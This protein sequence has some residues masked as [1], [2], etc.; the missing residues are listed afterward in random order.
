MIIKILGLAIVLFLFLL[1]MGAS[2]IGSIL[3]ALFGVKPTNGFNSNTQA[4]EQPRQRPDT[5]RTRQE[6]TSDK[7]K[8]FDDDEGEYVDF[9]EI[10]DD[11]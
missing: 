5:H 3:R 1:V 6:T 2:I 11:K 8:V 9:E 7:K 4:G 10:K